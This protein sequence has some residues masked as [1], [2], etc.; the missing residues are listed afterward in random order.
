MKVAS[1]ILLKVAGFVSIGV[2]IFLAIFGTVFAVISSESCRPWLEELLTEG[3]Y[4]TTFPGTVQEQVAAIQIVYLSVAIV[5][6]VYTA[7]SIVN[8]V[9]SFMGRNKQTKG[10]YIANIV[11]GFISSVIINAVGGIFGLIAANRSNE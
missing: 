9:V 8:A 6:F 4:T 2:A 3:T 1:N 11:V 7:L 10:A 5:C